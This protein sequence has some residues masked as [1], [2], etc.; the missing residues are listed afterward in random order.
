MKSHR[1]LYAIAIALALYGNAAAQQTVLVERD[2]EDDPCGLFKMRV[3]APAGN[4]DYKL[5]VQSPAEDIDPEM[6]WNPCPRNEPRLSFS[7]RVVRPDN[8]V[9]YLTPQPFG[10][11]P[12][13]EPNGGSNPLESLRPRMPLPFEVMRRR[14]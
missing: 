14:R 8:G 4:F 11:G 12:S 5:R 13:H 1:W 2:N 3:L 6:I 9:G 10:F 7:P